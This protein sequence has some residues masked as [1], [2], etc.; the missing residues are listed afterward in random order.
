MTTTIR[1]NKTF[2]AA[3][4]KSP[5][6]GGW[7]YVVMPGS[8]EYFGTRGLVKV[9]GTVDGHPFQT[10]FMALGDGTHKLPLRADLR[11]HLDKQVGDSVTVHL[12]E[13]LKR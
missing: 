11:K 13:R 6:A 9:K 1:L 3:I 2:N 7:T 4:R 5:A 12:R 10:S 8:A